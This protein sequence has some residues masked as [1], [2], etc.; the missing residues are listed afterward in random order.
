M[1]IGADHKRD[2]AIAR[3]VQTPDQDPDRTAVGGD[4]G[5]AVLGSAGFR[6]DHHAQGR[7]L[8]DV[9]SAADRDRPS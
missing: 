7:R 3:G 8:A 9:R 5:Y 6:P 1:A 4:R 2:R